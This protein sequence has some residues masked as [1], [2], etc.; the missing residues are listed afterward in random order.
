MDLLKKANFIKKSSLYLLIIFAVIFI[1]AIIL[2]IAAGASA[3]TGSINTFTGIWGAATALW[4]ITGISAVVYVIFCIINAVYI[5]STDWK[6]QKL[7][8]S[9]CKIVW[10]I[11][12]IVILGAIS[13]LIF[14]IKA[15][16][17]LKNNKTINN[18]AANNSV[19]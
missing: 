16:K 4:I 2:Q 1:I 8:D 17:E 11:F 5:L 6:N 12:T 10:G 19:A 3:A 14:G 7:N 13:S 9:S 15:E 18:D